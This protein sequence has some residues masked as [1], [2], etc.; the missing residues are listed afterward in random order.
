M[1]YGKLHPQPYISY[2]NFKVNSR[3]LSKVHT[4]T[5]VGSHLVYAW[6]HC[7]KNVRLLFYSDVLS[8]VSRD[9]PC[10]LIFN[11]KVIHHFPA[12]MIPGY[13]HKASYFAYRLCQKILSG[14]DQA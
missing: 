2:T 12:L 5:R 3:V 7:Q 6:I 10:F 9:S 13:P 8:K 1:L 14:E 11:Q 4:Y